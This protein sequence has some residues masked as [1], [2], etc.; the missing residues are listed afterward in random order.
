MNHQYVNIKFTFEVEKKQK[1]LILDIKTC[2]ENNEFT[3]SVF[4]KSTFSGIFTNFD[5]LI[6]I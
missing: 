5:S 1:L 2:R 3:T 6:P 4:R